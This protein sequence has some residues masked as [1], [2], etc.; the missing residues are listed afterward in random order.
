MYLKRL[1][2]AL[3]ALAL[4][5]GG[6]QAQEDIFAATPTP[7]ASAGNIG[8]SIA[9]YTYATTSNATLGVRFAYPSHWEM[10]PGRRTICYE[11]PVAEG[12]IPG[13]HGR[14]CQT[15]G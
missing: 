6:A 10:T 11:E 12:D 13:A 3:M 15:A 1:F 8:L 4:I 9:E 7:T 2:A 14:V 5:L